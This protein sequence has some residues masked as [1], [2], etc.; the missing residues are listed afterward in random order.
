MI[1]SSQTVTTFEY[2]KAAI[3]LYWPNWIIYNFRWFFLHTIIVSLN[4]FFIF[5]RALC[6]EEVLKI[7]I[8]GSSGDD[9]DII[10]QEQFLNFH[11]DEEDWLLFSNMGAFSYTLD[12]DMASVA[13]PS[14]Y[15][16]FRYDL[17]WLMHPTRCVFQN[18]V[19]YILCTNIPSF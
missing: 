3:L 16:K 1:Y 12:A 5:W 18:V 8:F 17:F 13:L 19:I 2:L 10:V 11:I 4:F 15:G 7:D 6:K 9:M 14:K